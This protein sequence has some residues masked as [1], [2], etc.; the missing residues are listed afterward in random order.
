MASALHHGPPGSFKTFTLVQRR[1]I[2]ALADGRIVVT[3]IRGFESLEDV[4]ESFPDIE[5]PHTAQ[6]VYVDTEIAHNRKMMALWYLW[7]PIGSLVLIDEVQ[8]IYRTKDK[9]QDLTA[10][11]FPDIYRLDKVVDKE[12]PNISYSRPDNFYDAFDMQRH[13]NW[14]VFMSSTNIAKVRSEIREVAEW[15]YRHRNISGLL[16]WK[17]SCWYEHQHD[18]EQSGKIASHR[19]GAPVEYKADPRIFKCYKSTATGDN[20]KSTAG[21]SIF[22]DPRLLFVAGSALVLFTISISLFISQSREKE[23]KKAAA[24]AAAPPAVATPAKAVQVPV[25]GAVNVNRD[26]VH[27]TNNKKPVV[28]PPISGQIYIDGYINF[29]GSQRYYLKVV[30]ADGSSYADTSDSLIKLG[31]KVLRVSDCIF[32]YIYNGVT[33][34]ASCSVVK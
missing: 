28:A 15:A 10:Q 25:Q 3:N 24:V 29:N 32:Y 21:R 33:Q 6:L 19:V 17:K 22:S 13:F 7:V 4:I 23:S 9:V 18:P 20:L 12:N 27:V 34:V 14:D 8:R 16:P 31:Y 1:A 26:A 5:F 30:A 2:P 11:N